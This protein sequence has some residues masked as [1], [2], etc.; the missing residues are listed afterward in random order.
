MKQIIL[1]KAPSIVLMATYTA[2]FDFNQAE[3]S[4][5]KV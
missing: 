4:L 5:K 3:I 1:K 2:L